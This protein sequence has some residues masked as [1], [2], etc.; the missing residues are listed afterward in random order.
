[1][2][3]LKANGIDD[4]SL[5]KEIDYQEVLNQQEIYGEELYLF[6][7]KDMQKEVIVPKLKG[8]PLGIVIVESGWGSMVPTVVLANMCPQGAAARCGQLNIG[9]Q[10]MSV[11][12]ISLVGLPLSSCQ[13][14]MKTARNQTVVKLTTV[15]CPPVVEVLIKRP[16]VKYQ[17]GFSVQ[18]GV[19]CSLLRGGIAERGGVRVGHRIIEINAQSVVAV[20][21]E[22]IVTMLAT[23]VGEIHMKTMPTSIFRLLTGQDTPHYI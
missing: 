11:N 10:I 21:H 2:E 19:I 20:P 4:P 16:D 17:L 13:T 9:D 12:G 3:F 5:I 1:M 18:N 6:S 8:E 15:S 14:Y 22:K 23:S 7:N